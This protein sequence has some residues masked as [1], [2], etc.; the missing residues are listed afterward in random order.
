MHFIGV[1]CSDGTVIKATKEVILASGAIN[2]PQLMLL[3]GIGPRDELEEHGIEVLHHLPGVG[4][5]L[6]D[7]MCINMAVECTQG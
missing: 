5:N 3:S 2:S 4:K 7:H 6:Q 1:V